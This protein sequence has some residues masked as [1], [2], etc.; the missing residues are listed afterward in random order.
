MKNK[1]PRC[2]ERP[3]RNEWKYYITEAEMSAIRARLLEIMER[4]SHA[5]DGKYPPE[6]PN[7]ASALLSQ[8]QKHPWGRF[9]RG[10]QLVEKV[11]STSCLRFAEL[12]KFCKTID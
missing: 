5:G 9:P 3:F 11:F 4:D 8:A 6:G 1:R 2:D 10:A 12:L 7:P